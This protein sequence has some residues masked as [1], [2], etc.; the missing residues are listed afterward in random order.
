MKNYGHNTN[1]I[2]VYWDFENIHISLCR[3][4]YG[5]MWCGHK[6]DKAAQ[7]AIMDVDSIMEFITSIGIVNINRAYANW[8]Y[9]YSYN[10][11]LQNHSIDLI[12][13]FPRTR[14][15]KNGSDIRMSID[16]IEDLVQSS[17][18]DTV[19]LIGGD[20]DYIAVSQKV[21][22]MG[23]QIIGI[24]LQETTSPFFV[25][26][27]NEFKFYASLLVRSSA[28]Q[29]EL[30]EE[31]VEDLGEA[32]DLLRKAITTLAENSGSP[33]VV[34]AAIKPMLIRLEPTFDEGNYGFSTFTG[35]MDA[36]SDIIDTEK[37]EYD[38]LVSLRDT[39]APVPQATVSKYEKILRDQ[40][41][42]LV[43][44]DLM[45]A[46][47]ACTVELF[48]AHGS[49]ESYTDYKELLAECL[50]AKGVAFEPSDLT[51]IKAIIFKA[52]L[53][54]LDYKNKSIELKN[55]YKSHNQLFVE[56]LDFLVKRIVYNSTSDVDTAE[57]ARL[58]L[59][60]AK[61]KDHIDKLIEKLAK[62][63]D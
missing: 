36:C 17:H 1:N 39:N 29:A 43:R 57:I 62:D 45:E 51:K 50:S 35:L 53:F 23:K 49:I 30:T 24:G 12:Q 13:L 3:I 58:L 22:Q 61:Q 48:K 26:S 18:I 38:I 8:T 54:K 31:S 52:F 4:H 10:E 33:K 27:C 15:G 16:I 56:V 20:S 41:I 47:L 7:P 59:G 34:K 6:G 44:H 63:C 5:D 14:A 40:G 11:V 28:Q 55:D 46:A 19:V 37:G 42:R 32:K 21:R 9:F 60:D 25:R 2:A